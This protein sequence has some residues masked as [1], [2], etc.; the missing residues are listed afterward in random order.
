MI[1]FGYCGSG[2]RLSLIIRTR[3]P[4]MTPETAMMEAQIRQ[5]VRSVR[6]GKYADNRRRYRPL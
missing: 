5:R 1:G 3:Y 4:E 2:S 6:L